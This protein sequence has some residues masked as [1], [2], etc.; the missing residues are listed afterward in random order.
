MKAFNLAYLNR[1]YPTGIFVPS[2]PEYKKDM[3]PQ[4]EE[5][6]EENNVVNHPRFNY[7]KSDRVWTL[8]WSAGKLYVFT[9]ERRIR[10]P[11]IASACINEPGLISYTRFKEILGRVRVKGAPYPQINLAGTWE[12]RNHWLFDHFVEPKKPPKPGSRKVIYASTRENADNLSEIYIPMLEENYDEVMLKA[13]MEG[14]PINMNGSMFYYA[15]TRDGNCDR[16]IQQV[17]HE[18]VHITMDFNVG[19]MT[20]AM[21]NIVEVPDRPRGPLARYKTHEEVHGFDEIVLNT[22]DADTQKMCNALKERG[23]D[24]DFVDIVIYPDT[25]GK[26]RKTTGKSDFEIL[27]QN[28]F[29]NIKFK[30]KAPSMKDR[31]NAM[32][33]MFSKRHLKLNPDTMPETAKDFEGVEVDLADGTKIKDTEG[34]K[35]HLS[36]G[37]DYFIDIKFPLSGKKPITSRVYG[38]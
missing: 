14:L 29:R 35:T 9:C 21:W 30:P 16:T 15:F 23:Y 26:S 11:N 25:S 2:V 33:N 12:G 7:H 36:D 37:A 6:L 10:G 38:G 22:W 19:Y 24:P 32:N 8:P 20:C 18:T 17:P 13:Y 1:P 34:K 27:K 31:R 3:L 28:G 4:M 5:I